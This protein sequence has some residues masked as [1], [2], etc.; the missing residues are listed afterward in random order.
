MTEQTLPV[1]KELLTRAQ[2]G[3]GDSCTPVEKA[4]N[5][6]FALPVSTRLRWDRCSEGHLKNAAFGFT[7]LECLSITHQIRPIML[8][9]WRGMIARVLIGSRSKPGSTKQR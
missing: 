3:G 5:R 4:S 8:S 1:F 7:H 9:A 6:C 2:P